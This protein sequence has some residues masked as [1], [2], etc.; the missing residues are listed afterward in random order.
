MH[1]RGFYEVILKRPMDFTLSLFAIILLS[2]ILLSIAFLVKIKIGSPIIFK[3]SRPG[4]KEN[5]FRL[6]KF[7]TMTNQ[8]DENGNLLPDE[9][10]LAKFGR[11]LR[12][13]SLDE[14]PSLFNIIKGDMSIVGPRP[15]IEIY[16]PY[17]TEK[18]GH[19]HDVRPGLTGLAQING[20]SFISWE[21]IFKYDLSYV[22]D[23]TFIND[24]KIIWRTVGKVIG[25][26]NIADMTQIKK[27]KYGQLHF[28]VDGNRVYLHRPLNV[29]REEMLNAKE[30]GSNFELRLNS[31]LGDF[32][33][34]LNMESF[35]LKGTDSI[36]LSTGRGAENLVLDTI[37]E[38]NPDIRKVAMIPPFTCSTVIE[39]FL[40]HGFE[41]FSYAI[42]NMLNV[43]LDEFRE[44]LTLTKTQVVLVH[45][46]FGFDT[47]KDFEKI[48]DEFSP[49][50]VIFI[51][52]KTQCLYSGFNSLQVDYTIGSIRKWAGLPNG[53]FAVCKTGVFKHRPNLY[54]KE[55]EYLKLKASY[56][57][58]DYL[59]N[60]SIEKKQYLNLFKRAEENLDSE[61]TYYN[62]SPMSV[63]IQ[64]NLDLPL[65]KKKRRENYMFLYNGLKEYDI[66]NA[67]M[68][69]LT[70]AEV[71]LY[72][73][74]CLKNRDKLQNH[75]RLY[76]IY[77]PII[78]TKAKT[79]PE[80]C[81]EAQNIY[82]CILCLPIDQRYGV[83]DMER[84]I[85]VIKEF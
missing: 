41:I 6:Y 10:R 45:R 68:P 58:F 72:F 35:A 71:P 32:D 65:L 55:H 24:V 73:V 13:T 37:L 18:E 23:I 57:K 60:N 59:L 20:R 28:T 48:V 42:D 30:I 33:S 19:R 74:F 49:K 39:P 9:V 79:S 36:F 25:R 69:K 85:K 38:R 12:S 47:L 62:I 8:K 43:K 17:F 70:E 14:I 44:L 63:S 27:D 31:V 22:S 67:L 7:R 4:K 84:I 1:R 76:N 16:L 83:D 26:N 77:A 56:A 81:S 5:L 29:E 80:I 52:D 64:Q 3:Q 66:L 53:G 21:V 75:L 82:D 78:W 15:L 11:M 61:L 54:N 40:K 50:G 2:P 46:Y 34:S 51:E